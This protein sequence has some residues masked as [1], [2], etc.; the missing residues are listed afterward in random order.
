MELIIMGG[1]I[2]YLSCRVLIDLA[3]KFSCWFIEED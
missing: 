3:H 1:G 2:V